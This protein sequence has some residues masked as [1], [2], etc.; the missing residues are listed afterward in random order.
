MDLNQDNQPDHEMAFEKL[1]TRVYPGAIV[2]LHNKSRTNGKILD[3]LLT[4]WEEMGTGLYRCQ[5]LRE[6]LTFDRH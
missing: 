5:S 6:R 2:L 4:R 3:A 1:T